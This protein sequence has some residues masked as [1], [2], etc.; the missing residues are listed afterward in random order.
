MLGIIIFVVEYVILFSAASTELGDIDYDDIFS[1]L[2]LD[3][4]YST[5]FS[6]TDDFVIDGSFVTP[7]NDY[8]TGVLHIDGIRVDF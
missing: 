7:D 4:I 3:D 6:D 5:S 1:D 2:D 8:F